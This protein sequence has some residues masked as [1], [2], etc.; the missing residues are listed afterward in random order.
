MDIQYNPFSLQGKN[1]LVTGTSS[2]IGRQVAIDCSRMGA[3]VISVARN[4]E[5]LDETQNLLQGKG[6]RIYSY[7]LSDCDGIKDLVAQIVTENGKLGGLVC[8]AGIEKT[9]PFKMLKP[10]DCEEIYK[11]NALSAFELSK[12][13]S[14]IKNFEKEGGCIVLISSITAVIARG[15]TVAYTASKGA[16]VSAARVMA[17][18]LANRKIRVN[19][20]SPGTVLTPLMKNYLS[21]L[22]EEDYRK[23]VSGFP[24]GL[25]DTTD[26]SYACVFLLC[27]ASRWVTGQN[28]VIDGGYTI[29]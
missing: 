18:E 12:N 13:V 2:G 15:G 1:I 29:K 22:S 16:L 11:V 28:I 19:C 14:N 7:D 21:T 20:I 5:R 3:R 4:K 17:T 6:H 23:R 10:S 25:G 8:A 24:L 9:R 26:I 27:D